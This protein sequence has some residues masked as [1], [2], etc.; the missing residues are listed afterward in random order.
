[1]KKIILCTCFPQFVCSFISVCTFFIVWEFL[2]LYR[3]IDNQLLPSPSDIAVAIANSF[4]LV[5]IDALTSLQRV[6]VGYAL[7][8][9][10]GIGTGVA[11]LSPFVKR[12]LGPL[13][14]IFRPI[15]PIAWIP[16][17]LLWFGVGDHP[18]YF[19]VGWV[20]FSLRRA[21]PRQG[22]ARRKVRIRKPPHAWG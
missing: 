7:G 20:P 19:L 4:G 1:M 16:L 8:S 22:F 21:E 11:L 2:C 15:P 9:I 14:E 3:L 5:F 13:V 12:T 6:G 18:A 17:S 10:T